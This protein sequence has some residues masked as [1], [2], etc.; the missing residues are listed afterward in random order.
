[1]I[2]LQIDD[3]W[4][5][6]LLLAHHL[7][8][9]G[10]QVHR[11]ATRWV[12]PLCVRGPASQTRVPHPDHR[13]FVPA[14]EKTVRRTGA[15]LVL[16]LFESAIY[17]LWE[18]DLEWQSRLFPQIEPWQLQLLRSKG[19]LTDFLARRGIEVPLQRWLHEP[20]DLTEACESIGFPMVIKGETG[21]GGDRVRMVR[22]RTEAESAVAVFRQG[23][24]EAL[25]AQT[26]IQ[27]ATWMSTGLFCE[28]KALRYYAAE[29]LALDPPER[30][31]ATS[32]RSSDDPEL[33]AATRKVFAAL[34]WTGL[35]HA[36]F[37]RDADGRFLFLEVNPRP[38]G[39]ITSA[40]DAGVELFGP[41]SDL[42][43]GREVAADCR[44]TSGVVSVIGSNRLRSLARRG[45]VAGLVAALR[46]REAWK[47]L[48][49]FPRGVPIH[50]AI[51]TLLI[52]GRNLMRWTTGDSARGVE[53]PSPS[54]SRP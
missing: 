50:L 39:S 10:H 45:T 30:G 24:Q 14:V 9:R 40:A 15:E 8:R 19:A 26:F 48:H 31:Q 36:D 13:G 18:A 28:G 21:L 42:L 4:P 3:G 37:I 16:P 25:L 44:M 27:G 17:R 22:N 51:R 38:W 5:S 34:R 6:A 29:K 12:D 11:L 53:G 54:D 7:A 23:R 1:M 52:W 47:S 43:A 32:M 41:F 49:H 35:A 46:D 20:A 33:A 2:L